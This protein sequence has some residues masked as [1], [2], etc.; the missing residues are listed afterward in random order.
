[1]PAAPSIRGGERE[2]LANYWRERLEKMD[3]SYQERIE[4]LRTVGEH[5]SPVFARIVRIEGGIGMPKRLIARQLNLSVAQLDH[6]YG[7]DYELGSA[8]ALRDVMANAMRIGS[9]L[10]DPNAG[11]VAMQI[12]DRRGGEEWRPPAQKLDV[13]S[14]EGKP[15]T[16]DSSQLTAEERAQMRLIL[17]NVQSREARGEG[18]EGGAADEG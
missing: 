15:R 8:E 5:P 2:L 18:G 1:M 12:L 6:H 4:L 16:I 11:R 9:S 14:S 10:T 13:T 7:D 3:R 17:E